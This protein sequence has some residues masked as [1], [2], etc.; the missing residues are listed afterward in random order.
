MMGKKHGFSVGCL[1]LRLSFCMGFMVL[2]MGAQA[3]TPTP[4]CDVC[5]VAQ[6]VLGGSGGTFDAPYCEAIDAANSLLYVADTGNN[7]IQIFNLPALTNAGVIPGFIGPFG[8]DYFNGS[9]YVGENN[10]WEIV[11][12]SN[13]AVTAVNAT[14]NQVDGLSVDKTNGDVYATDLT[15]L[16]VYQEN[17]S[18]GVTTYTPAT[19][20]LSG[21]STQLFGVLVVGNSMG[22]TLFVSDGKNT[23]NPHITMFTKISESSS[24]AS[25]SF[26]GPT[27]VINSTT[28]DPNSWPYQLTMDN[29]N[30]LYLAGYTSD[31]VQVFDISSN[32]LVTL[33]HS[34]NL[35][36]Q[37][38]G[39][40]VDASGNQYVSGRLD[41]NAIFKILPCSG[42]PGTPVPNPAS[43]GE[44]FI[45]PSPAKGDHATI[46]YNM[47][48]TGQITLKIWNEKAELVDTVTDHKSAGV[49]TT[50]FSIPGF[51]TGVYFYSVILNYDSG[52]F[53]KLGPKKFVV[54][55]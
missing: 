47:K 2:A 23:G 29:S 5:Q 52:K 45:Y 44:C 21:L 46:S 9:L 15:D 20:N 26:S 36:G 42:V 8:I 4:T 53:E 35:G 11:N 33:D 34:C 3:Q 7:Q 19:T 41:N 55:H 16:L 25:V 17:V 12:P 24:P 10:Q 13:N 1:V 30:H 14:P 37:P 18:A 54:I 28:L 6:T 49:Q 22:T 39:V 40:A 51:A 48:E 38:V 27:T 43:L 31:L 50:S 32:G